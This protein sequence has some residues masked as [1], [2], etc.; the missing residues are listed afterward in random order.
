[1]SFLQGRFGGRDSFQEMDEGGTVFFSIVP[2]GILISSFEKYSPCLV[3]VFF[4]EYI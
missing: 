1:M 2:L 4:Q 3:V